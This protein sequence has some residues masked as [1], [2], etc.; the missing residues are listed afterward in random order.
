[1]LRSNYGNSIG[2]S[3]IAELT[4]IY[5]DFRLDDATTHRLNDYATTAAESFL[6]DPAIIAHAQNW[7]N[8]SA[9][10]RAQA[11]RAVWEVYSDIL[12]VPDSV[13]F[14]TVSLPR[15]ADGTGTG[16]YYDSG[17][18]TVVVN[19]DEA[20]NQNFAELTSIL[21]HE[22]AHATWD[23]ELAHIPPHKAVDMFRDGEITLEEF[24]LVTNFMLYLDPRTVPFT[25]YVENPHEQLAFTG[26]LLYRDE[27]RKNGVDVRPRLSPDHPL[28]QHLQDMRLIGPGSSM[29]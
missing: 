11:A 14:D 4:K 2:Q 21:L 15:N 22:A 27:L 24:M 16:G 17:S 10:Q 20:A 9:A 6:E 29:T 28:H 23:R 3:D 5:S 26:E 7:D 19:I 1:L 8:Y 12:G 13:S 18:Q 25:Q